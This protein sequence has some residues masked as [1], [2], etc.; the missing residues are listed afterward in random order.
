MDIVNHTVLAWLEEDNQKLGH[1][2]VRPLL[3]ET[4]PFTPAEIGEWRDEGYIR[5]VPDKSE[6]RSSKERMRGLGNF[7]LLTLKGSHADKFKPN[8]SYAPAKGEKNRYIVYSNTVKAV[9]EQLFYE[10]IPE[11]LMAKAVTA[12]VYARQ[13]GKIHGPVDRQTGRDLKDAC[14]LPPDDPRIFS[15]TLPD[16]SVRLFYWPAAAEP[17]AEPAPEAAAPAPTAEE[18]PEDAEA[19][20]ALDQI[21]ALDRQM[22]RL[23]KE[24]DDPASAEK[25]QDVVI[26][27]DAGTPLYY[28]Q[29]ETE[30]PA[31][32]RNSLAQAVENNRR[33]AKPERT[34]PEKKPEKKKKPRG[35]EQAAAAPVA[36]AARPQPFA[37]ALKAEWTEADRKNLVSE[38]LAL[39]GA[40]EQFALALSGTADPVL[41]ALKAQLQDTEAERLMTV[42][43][44]NQAKAQEAEYRDALAA[45]LVKSE[46]QALDQLKAETEKAV[47]DLE[48]LKKQRDELAREQEAAMKDVFPTASVAPGAAEEDAPVVTAAHRVME[49]LRTAGFACGQNDAVALLLL[50]AQSRGEDGWRLRAESAADSRD[51]AETLARAL[52]GKTADCRVHHRVLQGGTAALLMLCRDQWPLVPVPD[53]CACVYMPADSENA[54]RLMPEIRLHQSGAMPGMP[55][56][57]PALDS[58]ALKNKVRELRTPLNP[59]A[60]E[61]VSALRTLCSERGIILP[62]H[63]IRGLTAF[64]E[65]AQ[66]L[67]EGGV[68]AALDQAFLIYAAPMIMKEADDTGFLDELTKALPLTRAA[69]GLK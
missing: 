7:C 42:M 36:A 30:A 2:R 44:L 5:V 9:P 59:A 41:A 13:G 22:M 65:A 14:P 48:E 28:A 4:G 16:G 68:S 34:E 8:K 69:L 20:T 24:T 67:M 35:Q 64:A 52:G 61:V 31:K 18:Q 47:A 40:R 43:N 23:V 11:S 57:C 12:R 15:V 25:P 45:G 58:V 62:L 6:Q 38:I 39:P 26:A 66:N 19:M 21:K 54:E 33:A 46:R 1:F 10:V 50:Y 29:V 32:R 63:M 51:A 37:E 55:A 3:R 53:E 49:S 27:D 60:Q 56:A 17:K